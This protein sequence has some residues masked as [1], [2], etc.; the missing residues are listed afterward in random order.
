MHV[1]ERGWD[2]YDTTEYFMSVLS[3]LLLYYLA[4]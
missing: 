1:A 4:Y 2:L 3:V